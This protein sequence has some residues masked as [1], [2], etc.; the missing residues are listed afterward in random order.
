MSPT[1]EPDPHARRRDLSAIHTA[2]KMLALTDETYRDL[3][4]RLTGKRSSADLDAAGRA[5]VLEEFRRL[6]FKPLDFKTGSA[7][8][9]KRAGTRARADDPVARK[10][11]AL[12]LS[13]WHLG[14]VRDPS[15]NALAAFAKRIAHVDALQFL[16]PASARKV[17]EALKDWCIREGFAVDRLP[18]GTQAADFNRALLRVLWIRRVCLQDPDAKLDA[19][20]IDEIHFDNW[21]RVILP[22][23]VLSD[24]RTTDA[25][26]SLILVK[27]AGAWLRKE[28]A[29]SQARAARKAP[30]RKAGAS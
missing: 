21:A 3:L 7:A 4:E 28:L 27:R 22:S 23:G 5:A 26:W 2:K 6:G 29:R 25:Y 9:S 17:V 10:M 11:R 12:W 19:A 30:V 1:F 15:E 18:E 14:A 16:P 13:L 24:W 8:A 20:P